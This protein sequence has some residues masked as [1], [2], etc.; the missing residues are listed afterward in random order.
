M[1]TPLLTELER[2]RQFIDET[3]DEGRADLSPE[4]TLTL[5]R[6]A[7]QVP[8]QDESIDYEPVPPLATSSAPVTYRFEGRGQPLPYEID[9]ESLGID[10]DE[11]A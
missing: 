3:L 2:F 1:S 10:E 11:S 9:E 8:E 5:F 7:E 4:E 6:Q